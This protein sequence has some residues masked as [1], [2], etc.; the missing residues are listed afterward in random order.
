MGF[1]RIAGGMVFSDGGH[2]V[3]SNMPE[4]FLRNPRHERSRAFLSEIVH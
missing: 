4:E 3:E 1:A 2:I